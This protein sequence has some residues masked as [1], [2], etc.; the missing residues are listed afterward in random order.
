MKSLNKSD[1][2]SAPVVFTLSSLEPC[3]NP[4]GKGGRLSGS[5]AQF[6]PSLQMAGS[7]CICI[8][9]IMLLYRIVHLKKKCFFFFFKFKTLVNTLN[10]CIQMFAVRQEKQSDH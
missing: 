10:V 8:T 2:W 7:A 1:S 5:R 3:S 6:Q 4:S 9:Y